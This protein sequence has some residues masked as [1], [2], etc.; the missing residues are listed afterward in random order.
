VED[1]DSSLARRNRYADPPASQQVDASDR[2][3]LG[4]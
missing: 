1:Y 3:T 4:E 2:L